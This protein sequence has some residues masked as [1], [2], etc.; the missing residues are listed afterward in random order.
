MI[1]RP[2]GRGGPPVPVIG[3]GTWRMGEDARAR[4]QEV[5]ALRLGLDLGLTH[6]DTAEMYGD[7]RAEEI[8]GEAIADR[9]AEVVVVTKVMPSG[10][11]YDGTL[12][13]FEASL[14]RLRT[15][16][17]DVYLLHWWGNRHP[18]GE[19]MR[20]METLVERGLLR[21][22]GVSNFDVPQLKA[23]QAALR[24]ERLLCNQVLYHLGD[25]GVEKSVLPFCERAGIAVVGYTPLARGG[26][27]RSGV[28]AEIARTH[29]R[30]PRQVALNFLTRRPSLFTIPKAAQLEHVRENAAALDFTLTAAEITAI[31][32][33]FK[34]R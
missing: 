16:Y 24:R 20:A 25:R 18:I 30:T 10:A 33:A 32:R 11:S 19:T 28:V 12:R 13:A 2:W 8:V 3:Q 15:S 4:D 26:F 29:G 5:A 27:L 21:G 34:R 14:K 23:A 6:I 7:G 9:R 1:T 22:I 17:V 31:D